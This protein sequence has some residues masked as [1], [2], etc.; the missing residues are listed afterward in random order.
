MCKLGKLAFRAANVMSYNAKYY[1]YAN[2]ILCNSLQRVPSFNLKCTLG[3]NSSIL[4][5]RN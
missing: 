4:Q 1:V 5:R 3:K 2:T